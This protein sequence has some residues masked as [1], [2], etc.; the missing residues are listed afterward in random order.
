MKSCS[1]CRAAQLSAAVIFG[2]KKT[3]LHHQESGIRSVDFHGL[4]E[5]N[6][7]IIFIIINNKALTERWLRSKLC[8]GADGHEIKNVISEEPPNLIAGDQ[9]TSRKAATNFSVVGGLVA[10]CAVILVGSASLILEYYTP[11]INSKDNEIA[12]QTG[13]IAS[14]NAT[15]S[16]LNS[17]IASLQNQLTSIQSKYTASLVT[18]LG[19]KDLPGGGSNTT[20]LNHLYITGTVTN[21]GITTAYNAGLHVNGYASDG[22]MLIDITVPIDYYVSQ[23]GFTNATGL[24]TIY[25]SQQATADISIIHSGNV[26]TWNIIPVFTNSP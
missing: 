4:S 1:E 17:Q 12:N 5:N 10:L 18:A 23:D 3:V 2:K 11:M 20:D 13:E 21:A 25:P 7:V 26:T 16:S 14:M 19:V 15:I 8:R 6:C 24:T 9:A 22:I